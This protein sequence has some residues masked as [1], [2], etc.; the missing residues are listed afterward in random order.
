[1]RNNKI[2]GFLTV[3]SL[4]KELEKCDKKAIIN[5]E[6]YEDDGDYT[7]NF[8]TQESEKGEKIVWIGRRYES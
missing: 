3:E 2:E 1:M 7:V 6:K 5:T 8:V 4:I